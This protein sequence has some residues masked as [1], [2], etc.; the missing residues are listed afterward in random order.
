MEEQR[1]LVPKRAKQER[2]RLSLIWDWVEPSVWT[3]KMLAA[4]ERGVKGGKWYSLIDKVWNIAN[5]QLTNIRYPNIIFDRYG[6]FSLARAHKELCQSLKLATCFLESRMRENRTYGSEGG[7][8]S[9]GS[10]PYPYL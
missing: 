1:S 9:N 2:E 7:E 3:D 10:L 8:P 6:F 4:L 5:L